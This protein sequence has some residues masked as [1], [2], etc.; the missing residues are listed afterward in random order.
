[1]MPNNHILMKLVFKNVA[2]GYGIPQKFKYY[3]NY[4]EDPMDIQGF[5]TVPQP[6]SLTTSAKQGLAEM[7]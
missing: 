1:M 7:E 2:T 6:Q 4:L 3:H 5:S